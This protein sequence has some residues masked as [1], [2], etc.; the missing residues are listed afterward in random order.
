MKLVDEQ[1]RD[2]K[3]GDRYLDFR[4]E[5]H[6]LKGITKPHKPSSTGRVQTS[7]GEYYPS[8]IGLTWIEREDQQ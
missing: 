8:V 7:R 2:A 5:V 4:G 1:K 6:T 3:I